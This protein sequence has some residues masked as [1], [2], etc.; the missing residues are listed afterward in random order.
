MPETPFSNYKSIEEILLESGKINQQQLEAIRIASV[1]TGQNTKDVIRDG[2]YVSA[3][4]Y[5]LAYSKAFNEI[6]ENTTVNTV[7]T[8]RN[9]IE[10]QVSVVTLGGQSVRWEHNTDED[11]SGKFNFI[12][13]VNLN[14]GT[15]EIA[16]GGL[17]RDKQRANFFNEYDLR[18]FDDNKAVGQKN[19]LIKGIQF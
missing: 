4:D 7:S 8:V 2:N 14:K 19:N 12:S 10:N 6:P 13:S 17:Y 16:T 1:N 9:N 5:A 11:V 15:L 3:D 18:P